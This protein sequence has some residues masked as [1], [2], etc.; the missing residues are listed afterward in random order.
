MVKLVQQDLK[1]QLVLV[2]HY[3]LVLLVQMV[4]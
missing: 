2:T 1:V 4:V 3:L